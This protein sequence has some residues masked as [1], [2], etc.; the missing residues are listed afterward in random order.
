M[1]L[2]TCLSANDIR[3]NK[4][5]IRVDMSKLLSASQRYR[6]FSLGFLGNLTEDKVSIFCAKTIKMELHFPNRNE[7][8]VCTS[9]YPV[10][11]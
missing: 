11:E 9:L 10:R 5:L 2:N 1:M 3:E 4:T 8:K 6:Y 7:N